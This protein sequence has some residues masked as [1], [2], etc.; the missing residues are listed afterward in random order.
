MK[1]DGVAELLFDLSEK[2]M[3]SNTESGFTDNE[4]SEFDV[5]TYIKKLKN[6]AQTKLY[7]ECKKILMLSFIIR[8]LHIKECMDILT[9]FW[10][11]NFHLFQ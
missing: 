8:L 9:C 10:N 3:Q 4:C 1:I 2:Y 11:P 6:D 7:P 5:P